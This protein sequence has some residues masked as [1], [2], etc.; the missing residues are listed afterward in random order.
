[1]TACICADIN[2]RNCP[3]HQNGTD[4]VLIL[5]PGGVATVMAA[6]NDALGFLSM[7]QCPYFDH[8]GKCDRGCYVEPACITDTP[9]K[10]WVAAAI[11]ALERALPM[12]QSA[13]AEADHG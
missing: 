7:T 6:V 12:D 8:E 11:T 10:G 13:K 9:T 2:A 1:M 4:D 3:V 5:P